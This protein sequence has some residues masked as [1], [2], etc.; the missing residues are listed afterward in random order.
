MSL[1][2][3]KLRSDS[4]LYLVGYEN[5]QIVGAKLPSNR[6]VLSVFSYNTRTAKLNF[7]ESIKLVIEEVKVFWGKAKIPTSRE[8]YIKIKFRKLYDEWRNLQKSIKHQQSK[9]HAQNEKQ[10]TDKLD[11]LFDIASADALQSLKGAERELLLTQRQKGRVGSLAGIDRTDEA[12][13]RAGEAIEEKRLKR[14][15]QEENRKRKHAIESKQQ[16]NNTVKH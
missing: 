7:D 8:D 16:C 3:K 1:P 6:Q 4:E 2:S 9:T 13:D 10:F 14:L 12:I 11:D 5:H 15:E